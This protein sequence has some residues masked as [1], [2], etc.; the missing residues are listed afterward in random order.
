MDKVSPV[1]V[2]PWLRLCS[3]TF[4]LS[5]F[6]Q[7]TKTAIATSNEDSE[8]EQLPLNSVP[9]Y[10]G[11]GEYSDFTDI[12]TRDEWYSYYKGKLDWK[13]QILEIVDREWYFVCAIESKNSVIPVGSYA[14]F[15]L[16]DI[17]ETEVC[18]QTY[19]LVGVDTIAQDCPTCSYDKDA[20][21]SCYPDKLELQGSVFFYKPQ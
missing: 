6:W 19:I 12:I 15:R 8:K 14:W 10:K 11:K 13:L 1:S 16:I 5:T 20:V 9:E 2:Q 4:W 18:F 7:P 17:S 3:T 21:Y